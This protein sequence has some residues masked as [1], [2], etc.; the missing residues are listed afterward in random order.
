MVTKLKWYGRN[1]NRD[2][3]IK[4]LDKAIQVKINNREWVEV[5]QIGKNTVIFIC[6]FKVAGFEIYITSSSGYNISIIGSDTSV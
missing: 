2:K 6:Y 1:Y 4:A 5:W 3:K